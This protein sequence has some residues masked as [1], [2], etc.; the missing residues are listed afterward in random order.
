MKGYALGRLFP[1]TKEGDESRQLENKKKNTW[2]SIL[3][4]V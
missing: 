4:I 3:T 1:R 2:R